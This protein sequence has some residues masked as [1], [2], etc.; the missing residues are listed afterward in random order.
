MKL[1]QTF[2]GLKITVKQLTPGTTDYRPLLKEIKKS[3][4]TH[5]VLDC[6]YDKI[7]MILHQADGLDLLTDYHNYL[8]TS[9]DADKIDLAPYALHNVNITGFRL[10][11][12]D[13]HAVH[14][15]LKKFPNGGDGKDNYLFSDN[16][17][18]HD[19]VRVYAKAL[20]DLD[21]LQQMAIQPLTCESDDQW[22][23]GE[24]VLGYIKEVE[25]FG[26]TGEIKFDSDG[27]RTNFHLDLMEKFHSRMKKNA[28]WTEK[29][30]SWIVK[31]FY[32]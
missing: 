20:N 31:V 29:G 14:Q 24:K 9:L 12:P 1:P 15:Y 4:E 25:Y 28:V 23:D 17:L 22:E 8:I 18:V 13:S 16:A 26:L 2:L 7:E 6:E 19:S 30:K 27:L 5:I 10:V 11:D 32:G 21:S 3:E